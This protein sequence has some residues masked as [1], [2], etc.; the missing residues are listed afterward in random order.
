MDEWDDGQCFHAHIV[1]CI[2]KHEQGHHT[3]NEHIKFTC[4]VNDDKYEEIISYNELMDFIQKNMKNDAIIWKFWK[5][6][7]AGHR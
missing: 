7:V 1:E 3:T 2:N 4:S 6:V 5:I